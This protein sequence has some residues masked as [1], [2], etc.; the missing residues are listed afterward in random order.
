MGGRGIAACAV[1]L[2]SLGLA[3]CGGDGDGDPSAATSTSE[4]RA[5]AVQSAAPRNEQ[6]VLDQWANF[7]EA[8]VAGNGSAACALADQSGQQQLIAESSGLGG[9]VA[10]CEQAVEHLATQLDVDQAGIDFSSVAE[11]LKVTF[12][13]DR[14]AVYSSDGGEYR[15]FVYVDGQWLVTLSGPDLPM[16]AN[17]PEEGN[18][19]S[20][21]GFGGP[22]E[23]RVIGKCVDDKLD[24][25]ASTP[26]QREI[27]TA[28]RECSKDEG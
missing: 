11:D 1:C 14:A 21:D 18:A 4:Q 7:S 19:A 23:M 10:S 26:S 20:G 5:Q 22:K 2:V 17:D 27:A 6:A 9:D 25:P 13:G 8:L 16:T 12:E 24:A 3:S 28:L 15:P